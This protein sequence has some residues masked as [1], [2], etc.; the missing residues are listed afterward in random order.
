MGGVS[1]GGRVEA[2]VAARERD[3][4][5]V[6]L[7]HVDQQ[8][9]HVRGERGRHLSEHA[10][11]LNTFQHLGPWRVHMRRVHAKVSVYG[12]ALRHR[13][14]SSTVSAVVIPRRRR[15]R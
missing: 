6:G 3:H 1:P 8:R 5:G 7:E 11:P 14:A 12:G 2:E 15:R 10:T 4:G 9:P 13:W